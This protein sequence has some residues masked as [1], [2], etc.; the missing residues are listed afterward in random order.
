MFS[1]YIAIVIL[2][3]FGAAVFLIGFAKG[4]VETIRERRFATPDREASE[5][6]FYGASALIAVVASAV[7]IGMVGV[8]PTWIYAGPL[9]AIITATGVGICFL[10]GNR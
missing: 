1:I 6:G 3:L 9:L 2:G 5:E 7:I 8:S 4:V 10:V